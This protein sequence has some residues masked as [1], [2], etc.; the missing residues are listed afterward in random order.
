MPLQSQ[1][2]NNL[3]EWLSNLSTGGKIGTATAVV[4]I[5]LAYAII[6]C[7]SSRNTVTPRVSTQG[8][9]E[10]ADPVAR[11]DI[12][13]DPSPGQNAGQSAGQGPDQA[14]GQDTGGGEDG[15]GIEYG[16]ARGENIAEK[17][18]EAMNHVITSEAAA[19]T[20]EAIGQNTQGGAEEDRDESKWEDA[21]ESPID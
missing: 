16:V 4:G 6:R 5:G 17:V 9:G 1:H 21:I 18:A 12:N 2:I 13:P 11:P 19:A 14:G 10:G 8:T 15:K 20:Q 3:A 7:S